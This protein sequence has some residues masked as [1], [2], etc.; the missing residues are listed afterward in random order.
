MENDP[1]LTHGGQNRAAPRTGKGAYAQRSSGVLTGALSLIALPELVFAVIT[2]LYAFVYHHFPEVVMLAVIGFV[3]LSVMFVTLSSRIEGRWYLML[4]VLCFMAT[5]M[6]T[7]YGLYNYHENFLQYEAYSANREYSNVLPSEPA[8]AHAD[9]G[10][11]E[12]AKSARIDTTKAVGYKQGDVYCVVPIMDDM[13]TSRVEYWAAGMNCCKQRADFQCDDAGSAD[14]HSG[15]VIL[16]TNSFF[17]SNR[18]VYEKA[19]RE[20]EAAFDIVSS[21]NPLF[22]RWVK[23]P[24]QVQDMYERSGVGYLLVGW[25]VYFLLSIILGAICHIQ[26]SKKAHAAP[27]P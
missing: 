17:P 5:V 24:Q 14:A 4:G 11:I 2:T 15:V 20:A 21:P 22:V 23:D 25:A 9:A 1:F 12:F 13:Q 8:A 10:K 3:A 27:R 6:G 26:S 19:V 7:L 18:D 16:D